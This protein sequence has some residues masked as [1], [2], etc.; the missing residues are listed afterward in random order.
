M[1]QLARPDDAVREFAWNYG[2]DHPEQAWLLH[3]WDVWVKNLHYTG[4]DVPHPEEYVPEF[5]EMSA[6]QLHGHRADVS[7][8][9][10]GLESAERGEPS[11]GRVKMK[12]WQ[13]RVPRHAT[14]LC[15]IPIGYWSVA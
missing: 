2:A 4:P 13:V 6:D 7:E 3:D 14:E 9:T 11:S 12:E 5:D 8:D 15:L 10:T 1:D